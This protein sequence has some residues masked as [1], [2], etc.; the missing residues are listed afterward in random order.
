MFRTKT[1]PGLLALA[2]APGL[3]CAFAAHAQVR[4][5]AMTSGPSQTQSTANSGKVNNAWSDLSQTLATISSSDA[6]GQIRQLHAQL[7][8]YKW[9]TVYEFGQVSKSPLPGTRLKLGAIAPM[10]QMDAETFLLTSVPDLPGLNCP[11]ATLGGPAGR[12]IQVSRSLMPG[13][14]TVT[15]TLSDDQIKAMFLKASPT[16]GAQ[17]YDV[18]LSLK[19]ATCGAI[20]NTAQLT[21]RYQKFQSYQ[22]KWEECKANGVSISEWSHTEKFDFPGNHTRHASVGGGVLFKC[23]QI[24]NGNADDALGY[25][26]W[27]KWSDDNPAPLNILKTLREAGD[28]PNSC[29]QTCIPII[30][31][32]GAS[33]SICVGLDPGISAVGDTA[34]LRLGAK[35]RAFDRDKS[36][37]TP[38]INV[39][40]PFGVAQSLGE[41]ADSAKQQAM[42]KMQA[43][44]SSILPINTTMKSN[45]Q[46]LYSVLN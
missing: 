16:S 20:Y 26:S 41:M 45:I 40:A 2:L 31:G 46:K 27:F 43:Q 33:A 39:P 13:M 38:V 8:N 42:L 9:R 11:V 37:C 25:D 30:G 14:P 7:Q 1:K 15:M 10:S 19:T 18:Y 22:P 32:G 5:G 17:A 44:I 34:P 12:P 21:F 28:S 24:A 35:F 3:L 36:L 4:S 29:P 23:G 6:A